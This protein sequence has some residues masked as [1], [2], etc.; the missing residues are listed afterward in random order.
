MT[1]YLLSEHSGCTRLYPGDRAT[2]TPLFSCCLIVMRMESGK[3]YAEHCAGT[4]LDR[5]S[6]DFFSETAVEALMVTSKASP[7]QIGQAHALQLKLPATTLKYY[8][9][10]LD[11]GS[12][13][14]VTVNE[15]GS[16]YLEPTETYRFVDY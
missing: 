1:D 2:A 15:D 7:Y 4:D 3:V 6:P 9:S 14:R 5:L 10:D 11:N 16:L 12:M 13:P 8:A